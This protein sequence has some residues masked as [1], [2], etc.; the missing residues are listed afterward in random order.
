MRAVRAVRQ[1]G[2]SV[3]CEIL[4]P[5]YRSCLEKAGEGVGGW[6]YVGSRCACRS[7]LLPRKFPAGP[8]SSASTRARTCRRTQ[9]L[10]CPTHTRICTYRRPPGPRVVGRNACVHTG[11]QAD[12]HVC[13]KARPRA[14]AHTDMQ[15]RIHA[16]VHASHKRRM[17]APLLRVMAAP[18]LRAESGGMATV[19]GCHLVEEQKGW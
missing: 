11:S 16:R 2:R 19:R 3:G 1:R 15:T 6:A 13:M 14:H 8:R 7:G 9:V 17:A 4:D 10:V 18:A 12:K 5:G